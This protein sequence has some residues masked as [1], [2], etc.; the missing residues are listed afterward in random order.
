MWNAVIDGEMPD[1]WPPQPNRFWERGA[2]AAAPHYLRRYYG[3][4]DV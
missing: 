3:I 4:A 2:R 1:F